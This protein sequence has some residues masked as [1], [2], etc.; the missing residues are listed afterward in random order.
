ML[1][2]VR[3]PAW[4]WRAASR[5]SALWRIVGVEHFVALVLN[6]ASAL[7]RRPLL[8]AIDIA[9]QAARRRLRLCFK[10]G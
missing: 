9:V 6:A 1:R 10:S 3:P 7:A 2:S 4:Q 8:V 5:S